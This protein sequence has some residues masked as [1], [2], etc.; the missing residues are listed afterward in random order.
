MVVALGIAAHAPVHVRPQLENELT[1]AWF[2]P[3]VTSD[4]HIPSSSATPGS[5]GRG[6]VTME[7]L[8]GYQ[9]GGGSGQVAKVNPTFSKRCSQHDAQLVT[10]TQ[11][12]ERR[13]VVTKRAPGWI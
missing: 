2:I 9:G 6:L 10:E 3:R 8:L 7:G 1:Y 5:D 13:G 11:K 4:L 12:K